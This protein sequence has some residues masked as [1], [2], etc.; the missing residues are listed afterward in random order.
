L[1][2]SRATSGGEKMA[3]LDTE[4]GL[5][6]NSLN[7]LDCESENDDHVQEPTNNKLQT[8][9]SDQEHCQLSVGE[10]SI[11]IASSFLRA[12]RLADIVHGMYELVSKQS[13]PTKR[14]PGVS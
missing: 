13:T 10:I 1:G 12:D 8:I 4:Q 2:Q 9:E 14:M 5:E 7:D 3:E 6:A 11:N